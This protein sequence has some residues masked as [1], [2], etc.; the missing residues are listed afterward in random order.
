MIQSILSWPYR[1]PGWIMIFIATMVNF[2]C[3]L[4]L[5]TNYDD[6]YDV[7][8]YIF[9]KYDNIFIGQWIWILFV[10]C[11]TVVIALGFSIVELFRRSNSGSGSGSSGGDNRIGIKNTCE[12]Q[13]EGICLAILVIIWLPTIVIAT[14][15]N[16]IA[17]DFGNTYFFTWTS[18]IVVI[19]TFNTWLQDWRKDVHDARR[20]LRLEYEQSK[21]GGY[22]D[23][24][25]NS[26]DDNDF[27]LDDDDDGISHISSIE[28]D[29]EL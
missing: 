28:D 13:L 22:V 12:S 17:S 1:A 4:D 6:V 25:N 11:C 10:C 24:S 26:M 20:Q 9:E 2:I 3:I 5:Y 27:V 14:T 16:G 7:A 18:A 19:R 15:D 23:D 29:G 21:Q 8:I